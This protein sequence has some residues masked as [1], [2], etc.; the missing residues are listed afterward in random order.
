MWYISYTPNR[1]DFHAFGPVDQTEF[2]LYTS[3]LA[4]FSSISIQSLQL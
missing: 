2:A 3:H 4:F 1:H